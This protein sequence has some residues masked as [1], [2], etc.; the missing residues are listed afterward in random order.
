MGEQDSDSDDD[1]GVVQSASAMEVVSPWEIR[2]RALEA[3]ARSRT[4]SR[5]GSRIVSRAQSTRGS[6]SSSRADL[7]GLQGMTGLQMTPGKMTSAVEDYFGTY[8]GDAVNEAAEAYQLED[9]EGHIDEDEAEVAKLTGGKSLGLGSWVDGFMNW[10]LYDDVEDERLRQEKIQRKEENPSL[11]VA[12]SER[13]VNNEGEEAEAVN[14]E[15]G[16][17]LKDAKWLLGVAS[18]IVF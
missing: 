9:K 11:S 10:V 3:D 13:A 2:R 4:Q 15:E 5:V 14:A 12:G 17:I 7:E 16:G 6:R 18:K 8:E 1:G